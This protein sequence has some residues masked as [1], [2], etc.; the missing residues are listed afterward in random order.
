MP[1]LP[2]AAGANEATVTITIQSGTAPK[3]YTLALLAQAQVPFNKDP[4][5]KD[6]PNTLVSLP[7]RPVTVSVQ[8]PG[9][10]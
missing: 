3:E 10:P 6:R 8:P 1:E 2:V 9:K 7:S 5:A 4:A